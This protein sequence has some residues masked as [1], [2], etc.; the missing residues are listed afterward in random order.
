MHLLKN[1]AI[2]NKKSS[3]AQT[4]TYSFS[5]PNATIIAPPQSKNQLKILID[6]SVDDVIKTKKSTTSAIFFFQNVVRTSKII[7]NSTTFS[8]LISFSIL[9]VVIE[10]GISQDFSMH[11]FRHQIK[12]HVSKERPTKLSN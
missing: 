2:E 11:C 10:I 4:V 1:D 3:G 7:R 9:I 5:K 8:C 12:E 6:T